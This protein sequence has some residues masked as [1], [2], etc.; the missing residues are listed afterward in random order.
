MTRLTRRTFVI[1]GVLMA[2]A[3]V[4][5]ALCATSSRP[6]APQTAPPSAAALEN[7]ARLGAYSDRLASIADTLAPGASMT[8][9]LAALFR[10]SAARSGSNSATAE[11]SAA[12]LALAFYV[13]GWPLQSLVPDARTWRPVTPRELRLRGRHDL[14]QH[15]AVSALIASA[16]GTPMAAMAGIYKELNDSRGGSGFSFSD[17]AADQ[18]GTMFGTLA[19]STSASARDIQRRIAAGITEDD[20]IP[21]VTDLA[22]NMPEAEFTR[23]F[24]GVGAPAYN[25]VIADITRRVAALPLFRPPATR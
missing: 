4:S 15:F 23:R 6:P 1:P 22:D 5:V 3:L 7:A 11:N 19:T 14:A 18:A 12:V 2:V 16:A 17:I 13:N 10:L 25:T 9:V 8:E 20:L 21:I 24:G